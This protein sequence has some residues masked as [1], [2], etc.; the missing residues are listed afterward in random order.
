MTR[1]FNFNE[2]TLSG[3][4]LHSSTSTSV[5]NDQTVFNGK[6]Y[7]GVV[8]DSQ[9]NGLFLRVEN[10]IVY[11]LVNNGESDTSRIEIAYLKLDAVPGDKWEAPVYSQF[12]SEHNALVTISMTGTYLGMEPVDVPAGTFEDCMKFDV[13]AIATIHSTEA[14]QVVHEKSEVW[15]AKNIGIVKIRQTLLEEGI[16]AGYRVQE[17]AS[18]QN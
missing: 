6:E 13:S 2:T 16:A 9:P 14:V 8:E 3:G 11:T 17:L 4:I 5:L 10:D 18:Y 12:E 7:W 1:T 15:L